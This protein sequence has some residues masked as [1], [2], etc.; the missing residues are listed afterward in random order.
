MFGQRKFD[1]EIGSGD[2]LKFCEFSGEAALPSVGGDADVNPPLFPDTTFEEKSLTRLCFDPRKTGRRRIENN[3]VK[4]NRFFQLLPNLL[5]PR[6]K[7]VQARAVPF[8]VW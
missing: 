4:Q 1:L 2:R 8:S 3:A 7:C 5:S 6:H